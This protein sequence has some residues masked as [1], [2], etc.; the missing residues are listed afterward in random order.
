MY[1][2]TA[3]A[4]FFYS[5][6]ENA[7][8]EELKRC[9]ANQIQFDLPQSIVAAIV[10]H[11]GWAFSGPIAG[12]VYQAIARQEQPET[13]LIFG[14]VHVHGVNKAALWE[15]GQWQTP[16]GDVAV[17]EEL[18][19]R[20]LEGCHG[21]MQGNYDAHFRE[22]SI[23]V[24]IPFI[25][26]LFP[27]SKIVPLMVPS[28]AEAVEIGEYAATIIADKNVVVLGSTDMTHYGSRFGFQPAGR[29]K[30]SLEWVKN[31]NDKRMLDK[32]IAL[33]AE[34]VVAEAMANHN[35][36]G[37]GVVAATLSFARAKQR[38]TGK[39]LEYTTSWDVYPERDV[40]SFVGYAGVIF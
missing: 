28:I 6:G 11:A 14:A 29:G 31:E 34:E 16:L 25:K 12:K 10:P 37:A 33:A 23:E 4:G 38:S 21:L 8:R 26:Y 20:L 40:D 13:F 32:I 15:K 36:C 17:D 7:C 3:Q 2:K 24:Q 18:A 27:N 22:H 5:G 30:K 1:R 9:L 19:R 35:A 39:L